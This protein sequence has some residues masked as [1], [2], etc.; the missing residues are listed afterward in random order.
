MRSALLLVLLAFPAL[1]DQRTP[2]YGT[3]GSEA[4]CTRA[5]IKP[6]GTV[7]AAP[8][9]IDGDWLKHGEVWCL[10]NW[11][12]VDARDGGLF[13]AARAQCGEDSLREYLLR[14]ELSGEALTL[15]WSL[16]LKNGPLRRCAPS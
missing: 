16:L 9:E 12:P 1:A 6:G 5:P 7:L 14:M 8:F 4:Q 2:F 13:S 11:F 10:L 3:W 15:R